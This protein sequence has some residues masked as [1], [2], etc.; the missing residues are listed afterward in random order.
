MSVQTTIG[1]EKFPK[2]NNSF[3]LFVIFLVALGLRLLYLWLYAQP[4]PVVYDAEGYYKAGLAIAGF[5][6][7]APER[8]NFLGMRGPGYALFL[9]TIFSLFSPENLW[10]V[11]YLQAIIGTLSCLVVYLTAG[12]LAGRRVAVIAGFLMAFYPS[13][14]LLTERLITETL[15]IFL[16]WLG[17]YLL[18]RGLRFNALGW[19]IAAGATFGL[20]CLTRPTL[21][22]ALP[23]LMVA[24]V[25][26]G[27]QATIGRRIF[28]SIIFTISVLSL[29]LAWNMFIRTRVDT[30]TVGAGGIAT[31][32]D[33]VSKSTHPAVRG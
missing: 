11:R 27:Q 19:L 29:L 2:L 5:R 8:W 23:F 13:L 9:A 16:F 17:L 10:P 7:F 22:P 14:I 33:L 12:Q 1:S 26:S 25:V 28:L 24:V 32:I 30:P 15:A 3:W 4:T 21:L 20:A 18:V 31:M 6:D